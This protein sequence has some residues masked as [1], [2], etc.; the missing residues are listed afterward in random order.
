MRGRNVRGRNVRGR[1]VR[2]ERGIKGGNT[3]EIW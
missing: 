2:R 3:G 1:N